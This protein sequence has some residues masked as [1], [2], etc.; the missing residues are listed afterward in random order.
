MKK[1]ITKTNYSSFL[2]SLF[3]LLILI[4]LVYPVQGSQAAGN[5]TVEII[6][7]Y[8]LVVDSN[9]LSPSSN[10]PEVATVIGKFC[11]PGDTTITN[12]HGYIGNY[13]DGIND[14]PGTYP[15]ETNP[16]RDTLTYKGDYSFTHLGGTADAARSMGSLDA[17]ECKYQYWSFQYPKTAINNSTC[18]LRSTCS[19]YY[20]N[21][22][23]V[24]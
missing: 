7:A 2:Y 15:V 10:M 8:N 22:I 16:V 4:S 9:V 17:G 20:E 23:C 12:V 11:N 14:T 18:I 5:L 21:E 19:R 3:S 6:S 13:L 1:N 24:A